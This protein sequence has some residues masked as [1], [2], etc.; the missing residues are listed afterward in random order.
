MQ[1]LLHRVTHHSAAKG[2]ENALYMISLTMY[3]VV[4][5]GSCPFHIILTMTLLVLDSLL[6]SVVLK[7]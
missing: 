3:Y 5:R 2:N 7:L 4:F 6:M 1:S